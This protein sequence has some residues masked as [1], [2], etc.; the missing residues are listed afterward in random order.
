MSVVETQPESSDCIVIGS[1]MSGLAVACLLA[2]QGKSV[3]ILE[4]NYLPGGC[5]SSY[6]RKGFVF[7]A[8]ATTIVGLEKGQPLH[9][10]I[11][12]LGMSLSDFPL[13]KL[14]Y[15]MQVQL[16]NG[17]VINRHA[18]LQD[19][20]TESQQ[21]FGEEGQEKFWKECM[22]IS[23]KV[24]KVSTRQLRF[25]WDKPSDLARS[26]LSLRGDEFDLGLPLFQSTYNLLEKHG[27]QNNKT[28]IEFCDQQLMITAQT[29][30]KNCNALFGAAALCYTLIGNYYCDGGMMG[31]IKPFLDKFSSL[32]GELLLRH[33]TSAIVPQGTGYLIKTNKGDFRAKTVVCSIPLNNT[34]EIFDGLS[35]DRFS[36]LSKRLFSKRDLASALQVSFAFEPDRD[37]DYLHY[38]LHLAET[39]PETRAKSIFLSLSHKDDLGR[40]SERG[41]RI[42]SVSCHLHLAKAPD[43]IN[44]QA[45]VD[46]I[47]D[48]LESA[49]LIKRDQIRYLH[50]S[51]S[52][53]WQQWT[54]RSWGFVGGYPQKMSVKPWQMVSHRLDG[55][56][57]YICGDSTYPGQ[58]LPGVTLSAIITAEKWMADHL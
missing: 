42:A 21:K 46:L 8:G 13:R 19:W 48:R 15:P 41:L 40:S 45:A 14:S 29:D 3:R 49:G 7:E 23:E 20:I 17:L 5:T 33:K 37:Y 9:H 54:G 31:L 58:G 36:A 2:G 1:G 4:Q 28:F 43:T 18:N 10:L 6:Q 27:L 25:P 11:E 26:I 51:D 12:K 56:G 35:T 47:L 50:C 44:K 55:K 16:S 53:D 22:S 30:T 24:W 52:K 34:L 38:Q 32:N 57:A 39:M